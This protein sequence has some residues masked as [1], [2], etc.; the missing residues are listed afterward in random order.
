MLIPAAEVEVPTD[1]VRRLLAAQ[2]L[3]SNA[4]ESVLSQES[5]YGGTLLAGRGGA[6]ENRR[7]LLNLVELARGDLHDQIVG[8]VVGER[9]AAAVQAVEGD[10]RCEREP[11]IT[12]DQG[13]VARQ[14]VQ[15]RG[16]LGIEG[17][18]GILAERRSPRRSPGPRSPVLGVGYA[19]VSSSTG[20]VRTPAV[21]RAYSAKPG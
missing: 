17:R 14:R 20:M 12:V 8:L 18:V 6:L 15:Q 1:L 3:C 19:R 10:H 11:F 5:R 7:D 21:W 4:R 13:V 16:C 9:Q 2:H